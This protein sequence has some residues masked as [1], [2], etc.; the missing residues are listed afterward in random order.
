MKEPVTYPPVPQLQKYIAS[1]G[2]LEIPEGVREPYFSPPLGLSGIILQTINTRNKMIAR[3]DDKEFFAEGAVVTGQ[4]TRPVHGELNGITKTLLVFFLPLGMYQLFGTDMVTLTD[5]SMTLKEF[6]G[7]VRSEKLMQSLRSDQ[8]TDRQIEVLNQFFMRIKPSG[9]NSAKLECVLDYIHERQ[10]GVN[11]YDLQR[12]GYYHR[13]MLERHF[14]K[15]VGLS[16]KVYAQIYRFKSPTQL[17]QSHPEITWSQL[18]D[19]AGYYDQSHMS[20]YVKEY[21]NVSPNSMV[22]LDMEFINYLLSR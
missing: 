12:N 14:K 4:V 15:M 1:Y 17:I 16:P 8:N 20:R 13:K 6:V 21:L 10:G 2:V 19:Q 7:E 5:T 18:A 22:Q 3:I 9:K 11:V